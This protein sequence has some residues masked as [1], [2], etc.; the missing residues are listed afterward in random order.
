[1]KNNGR[2]D[3]K[4]YFYSL[5]IIYFFFSRKKKR[6]KIS[7]HVAI[8]VEIEQV[9]GNVPVF[10]LIGIAKVTWDFDESRSTLARVIFKVDV[11]TDMVYG[12]GSVCPILKVSFHF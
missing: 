8:S 9:P 6:E 1:M 5:Q 11:G 10:E 3:T 12:N 7:Y 2:I 4:G